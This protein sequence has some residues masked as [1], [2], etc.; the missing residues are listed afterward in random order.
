V[1]K[2]SPDSC[3]RSAKSRTKGLEDKVLFDVANHQGTTSDKIAKRVGCHVVT[4]RR[5]LRRLI[6]TGRVSRRT[7]WF[8]KF[9]YTWIY[10]SVEEGER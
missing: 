2:L 10:K 4:V 1:K 7:W 8:G 5:H 6:D 3:Q 9:S